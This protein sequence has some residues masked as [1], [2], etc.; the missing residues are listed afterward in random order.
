MFIA[1]APGYLHKSL[2]ML[3]KLVVS[4]SRHLTE[5]ILIDRHLIDT[6]LKHTHRQNDCRTNCIPIA[7]SI[8]HCVRLSNNGLDQFWIFSPTKHYLPK[9]S[10]STLK[11]L[12]FLAHFNW[13][14]WS[15]N[16]SLQPRNFNNF[17]KYFLL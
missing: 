15:A 1:A 6:T 5:N 11:R 13:T 2:I 3:F 14:T 10:F 12:R 8:K 17:C 7:V 4:A 9:S 16:P